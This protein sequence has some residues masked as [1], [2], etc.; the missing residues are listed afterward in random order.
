M[1]LSKRVPTNPMMRTHAPFSGAP[2]KKSAPLKGRTLEQTTL[3][4]R[5]H[6][7]TGDNEVIDEANIH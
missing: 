7:M 3:G 6:G 2:P 5:E 4:E 1:W